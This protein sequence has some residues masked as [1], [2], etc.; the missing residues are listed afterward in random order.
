MYNRKHKKRKRIELYRRFYI[1]LKL[2]QYKS[3]VYSDKVGISPCEA[4]KE[5][6]QNK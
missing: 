5:V 1:S 3:V 6:T 4:I 2:G